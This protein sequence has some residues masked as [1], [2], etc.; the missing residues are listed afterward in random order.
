MSAIVIRSLAGLALVAALLGINA[1]GSGESD[2]STTVLT[3]SQFVK[4]G[5]AVCEHGLKEVVAATPSAKQVEGMDKGELEEMI[6]GLV[7]PFETMID[8]LQELPA[9]EA[10]QAKIAKILVSFEE[11]LDIMDSEP[12]RSL[13]GEYVFTKATEPASKYGLV[14]CV[15]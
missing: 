10:D 8:E 12:D 1:C 2:T 14:E 5:N 3:K 15:P 11:A 13:A 9:P 4:Q 6:R 7:P